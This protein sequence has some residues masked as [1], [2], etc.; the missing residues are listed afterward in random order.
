MTH[1]GPKPNI[2]LFHAAIVALALTGLVGSPASPAFAQATDD[3]VAAVLELIAF[4]GTTDKDEIRTA[5]AALD[6]RDIANL[7]GMLVEPGTGDD[8]K[9]RMALHGLSLDV[10][11]GRRGYDRYVAALGEAL[12]SDGPDAVKE[13]LIRQLQLV[14]GDDAAADVAVCLAD[15][16]LC[17]AAAQA[18][19]AIG[20]DR[21]AT[22]LRETLPNAT[23]VRRVAITSALGLMRDRRSIPLMAQDI[24]SDDEDIRFAALAALANMGETSILDAL[25]TATKSESWYGMTCDRNE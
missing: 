11:P 17:G 13:Y 3:R 5:L 12:T 16:E 2:V 10:G 4:D 19:L 23:G 20:G 21:A 14:G 8:T 18:L 25:D 9:A 7:C 1:T 6:Q 24:S 15:D 22:A